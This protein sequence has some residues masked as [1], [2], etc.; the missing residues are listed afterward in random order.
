MPPRS[1]LTLPTRADRNL[2]S[3]RR[4]RDAVCV[5]QRGP[6]LVAI[7][8]FESCRSRSVS[9][10]KLSPGDSERLFIG[11]SNACA[12]RLQ[13]HHRIQY[14]GDN[15]GAVFDDYDDYNDNDRQRC[16]S[17]KTRSY[18]LLFIVSIGAT[19][20]FRLDDLL[21]HVEKAIVHAHVVAYALAQGSDVRSY[22]PLTSLTNPLQL[23]LPRCTT[24]IMFKVL[25][26]P[27]KP[28]A[29]SSA[30][31]NRPTNWNLF[32]DGYFRHQ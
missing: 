15:Y 32:A 11:R 8:D 1:F 7:Y 27:T 25:S 21:L 29:A 3:Q 17:R 2:L 12:A 19:Q 30:L 14:D 28:N 31:P 9:W 22:Q 6:Q 13:L 4:R 23:S 18:D 16:G 24:K 5:R 10:R 20:I 26:K